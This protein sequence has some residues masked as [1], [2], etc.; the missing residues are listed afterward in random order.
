MAPG[1]GRVLNLLN[2]VHH[3]MDIVVHNHCVHKPVWSPVIGGK[4]ILETEE[5]AS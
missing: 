3:K 1:N 5:P 4:L 2:T